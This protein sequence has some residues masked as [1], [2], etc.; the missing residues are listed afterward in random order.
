MIHGH[1]A[2]GEHSSSQSTLGRI[3]RIHNQI[4][5]FSLFNFSWATHAYLGYF[6]LKPCNSFLMNVFQMMFGLLL[7]L[8]LDLLHSLLQLLSAASSI[9]NARL[10]LSDFDELSWAHVLQSHVLEFENVIVINKSGSGYRCYILEI[11]LFNAS[12]PR[13]IHCHTFNYSLFAI[14]NHCWSWVPQ[15][16]QHSQRIQAPQ[17]PQAPQPLRPPRHYSRQ[18]ST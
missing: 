8:Q 4:S 11:I 6:L 16:C 12:S 7:N 1:S 17:A 18:Y 15:P 2:P 3:E 13:N 10:S 9:D 5:F 14:V